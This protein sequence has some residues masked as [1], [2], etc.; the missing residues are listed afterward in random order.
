MMFTQRLRVQNV[1]KPR[2]PRSETATNHLPPSR[3]P[4][5]SFSTTFNVE[6]LYP[7][8]IFILSFTSKGEELSVLIGFNPLWSQF[9]AQSLHLSI[10]LRT[11][12]QLSGIGIDLICTRGFL[13]FLIFFRIF[14]RFHK[15]LPLHQQ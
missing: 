11:R 15:V 4:C 9:L 1:N 10:F 7:C 6:L 5:F 12:C 8:P 14:V 2:S 13:F 3:P